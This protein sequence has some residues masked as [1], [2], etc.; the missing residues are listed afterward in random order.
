VFVAIALRAGA[1]I[2]HFKTAAAALE[3]FHE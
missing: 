3:H 1:A 2:G